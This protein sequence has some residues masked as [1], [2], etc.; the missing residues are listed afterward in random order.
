MEIVTLESGAKYVNVDVSTPTGIER[1]KKLGLVKSHMADVALTSYLK[2]IAEVLFDDP[3]TK[4]KDSPRG[5]CFTLLRH[6]VRRAVSMFYY[7]QIADWEETYH[8]KWQSMTLEDYASSIYIEN[9]WM[10]RMLVGKIS[11]DILTDDELQLAKD[12]LK[13]KCL[14]GILDNDHL[15]ESLLRFET[16]FTWN[17][18]SNMK[19]RLSCQKEVL[20]R[21]GDNSHSHP[22]IEENSDV[23]NQIA[24]HNVHDLELFNY[25]LE[26]YEEQTK[27]F[28]SKK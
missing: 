4:T 13:N 24:Q 3:T 16:Y 18:K 26:L 17:S 9:D 10:T 28:Q 21:G 8:P 12:I 7:L 1:A 2:E 23:W 6:P 25:A 27:L 20:N 15:E 19:D 11:G 5:R 22:H 14:I